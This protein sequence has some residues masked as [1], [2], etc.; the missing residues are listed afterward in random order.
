MTS[1][2]VYY[3]ESAAPTASPAAPAHVTPP[4]PASPAPGV[5]SAPATTLSH[6]PPIHT[7]DSSLAANC[8]TILK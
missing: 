2:G 5:L 4:F 6:A 3:E 8:T 7:L 1:Q